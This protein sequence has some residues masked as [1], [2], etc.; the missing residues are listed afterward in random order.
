MLNG[1]IRELGKCL[2]LMMLAPCDRLG[3]FI[4]WPT[5][6]LRPLSLAALRAATLGPFVTT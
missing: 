5:H 3:S 1:P 2:M 4:C 6:Y